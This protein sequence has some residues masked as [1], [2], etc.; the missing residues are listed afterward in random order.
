MPKLGFR[1]GEA[2]KILVGATRMGLYRRSP[3][4]SFVLVPL[5][6]LP[7]P[8]GSIQRDIKDRY[9][10]CNIRCQCLI[11][12]L[13]VET[14]RIGK[15]EVNKALKGRFSGSNYSQVS[16]ITGQIRRQTLVG[17]YTDKAK[18]TQTQVY[19]HGRLCCVSR[20]QLQL[21]TRSINR[22]KQT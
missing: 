22:D 11:F 20:D 13:R 2:G 5:P 21:F 17:I 8:I 7:V 14:F 3:L 4:A 16:L 10:S 15:P 19:T 9:G 6:S 1:K 18:N 12:R